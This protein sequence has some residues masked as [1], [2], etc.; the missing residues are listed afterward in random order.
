[1]DGGTARHK[2]A[3]ARIYG[4]L[5]KLNSWTLGSNADRIMNVSH[6]QDVRSE[7]IFF[8][9]VCLSVSIY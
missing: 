2:I 5:E 6:F 9:S 1:M 3:S 8:L 4:V 7:K